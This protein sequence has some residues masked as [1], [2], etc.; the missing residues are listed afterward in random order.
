MT[1]ADRLVVSWVERLLRLIKVLD[2]RP[3]DS[4][5]SNARNME[6]G[7]EPELGSVAAEKQHTIILGDEGR[8]S[9]HKR[10]P[11][12]SLVCNVSSIRPA[13]Q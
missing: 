10:A 7:Q 11:K 6:V 1:G 2:C 4:I 13:K 9:H 8:I 5:D 3:I 12:C